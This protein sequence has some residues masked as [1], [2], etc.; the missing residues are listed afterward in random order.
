MFFANI[1]T[2]T[3]REDDQAS[4]TS[5]TD[6]MTC[7]VDNSARYTIL[8]YLNKADIDAAF[9]RVHVLIRFAL[10]RTKGI[11]MRLPF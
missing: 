8:T 7:A 2:V 3:K 5:D 9:R 10:V 6:S 4:R 1:F 11:F